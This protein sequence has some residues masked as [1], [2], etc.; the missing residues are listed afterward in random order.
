MYVRCGS[1][2]DA[3]KIFEDVPNQDVVS[4]G[5]IITAYADSGDWR[6]ACN[7][8]EN[9]KKFELNPDA[10]IFTNILISCSHSGVLDAGL[11]FFRLI[12]SCYGLEPT[13]LHYSLLIDLMARS[14]HLTLAL[15]LIETMPYVPK[16]FLWTSILTE[17]VLY[18]DMK[19][20][21]ECFDEAFQLDPNDASVYILILNAL[22]NGRLMMIDSSEDCGKATNLSIGREHCEV[23]EPPSHSKHI[24]SEIVDYNFDGYK[25]MDTIRRN[26]LQLFLLFFIQCILV[27]TSWYSFFRDYSRKMFLS[28]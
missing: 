10:T 24:V 3:H 2:K 22:M 23:V 19:L 8:L 14:G 17:C 20:A 18:G 7:C 16:S 9:M 25:Y 12:T 11:A 28:L 15:E 21:R 5:S 26:Y 6:M 27:R 1:F 13:L 4:W